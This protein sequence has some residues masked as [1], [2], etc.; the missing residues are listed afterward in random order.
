VDV[1]GDVG[2]T[3]NAQLDGP[4]TNV[5]VRGDTDSQGFPALVKYVLR[6]WA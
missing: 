5:Q 1:G 2:V 4:L 6:G 3:W